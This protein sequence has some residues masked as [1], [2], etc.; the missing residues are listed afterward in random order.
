MTF[1]SVQI[2]LV[3]HD[4]EFTEAFLYQVY[5]SCKRRFYV[6]EIYFFRFDESKDYHPYLTRSKT[7]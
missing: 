5:M 3:V 2:R 6:H 7:S 4:V 1:W